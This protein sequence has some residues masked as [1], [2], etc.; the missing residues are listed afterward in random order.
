MTILSLGMERGVPV[1]SVE[2]MGVA[3]IEL[4]CSGGMHNEVVS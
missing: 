2:V 1:V 3:L 4:R